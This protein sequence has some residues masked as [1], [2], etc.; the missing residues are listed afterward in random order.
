MCMKLPLYCF[1]DT[2][3]DSEAWRWKR[4]SSRCLVWIFV[5]VKA[6]VTRNQADDDVGVCVHGGRL[7]Q[8][9]VP[10]EGA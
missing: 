5:T 2:N 4:Y 10:L 8:L 1:I 9:L 7:A 6:N 3:Y